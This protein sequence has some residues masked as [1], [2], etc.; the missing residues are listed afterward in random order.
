MAVHTAAVEHPIVEALVDDGVD[1]LDDATR[2]RTRFSTAACHGACCWL[3]PLVTQH[4]GYFRA[5]GLPDDMIRQITAESDRHGRRQDGGCE[6]RADRA[7]HGLPLPPRARGYVG[8]RPGAGVYAESGVTGRDLLA[9]ASRTGA[10]WLGI[11]D[12][13]GL[14]EEGYVGMCSCSTATR[15]T[16]SAPSGSCAGSWPGAPSSP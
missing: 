3:T 5:I 1:T 10:E 13:V 8:R 11:A 12:E 16:A 4:E 7:R 9:L 6:R 15:S 14:V 2:P